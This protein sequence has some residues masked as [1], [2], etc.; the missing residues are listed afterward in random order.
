ESGEIIASEFVEQAVPSYSVATKAG[1]KDVTFGGSVFWRKPLGEA[2][3][4]VVDK[5]VRRVSSSVAAAPWSPRV[6]GVQDG[7]VLI[8]GGW[9]RHVRLGM[10]LEVFEPGGKIVDP[11]TGDAIGSHPGKTVGRVLITQVFPHYS[12]ARIVSGDPTL[13]QYGQRCA[14][15]R[16]SVSVAALSVTPAVAAATPRR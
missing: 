14:S 10:Q 11:D 12:A 4:R 3:N 1:Y 5:C 16:K 15:A 8:N 9:D 13:I 6:A 7:Q 2:M